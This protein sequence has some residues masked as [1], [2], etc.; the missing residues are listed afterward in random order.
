MLKDFGR[1]RTHIVT[2]RNTQWRSIAANQSFL[3]PITIVLIGLVLLPLAQTFYY[4]LTN[5]NGYS[6]EM[7]F[8]GFRNY[9]RLFS[10]P[11][12][13]SSLWF[14]ALYTIGCVVIVTALAVPTAVILNNNFVGRNFVRSVFFFPSILSIAILGLVWGFLLSPLAS[15]LINNILGTILDITPIPWLSETALAQASVIFVGVWV[16]TGWHAILYLA[17]LQSIPTDYYEAATLDGATPIQQF[18]SIT[19]PLLVPAISISSL[20]LVT[21]GLKVYDL[22]YTLTNGGPGYSTFTVT[23]AIIQNGISQGKVGQ[24]SALSIV[25]MLAVVLVVA[26][27]LFFSR[28][29]EGRLK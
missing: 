3:I 10:D 14:T 12:M 1:T 9:L 26:G 15:G 13:T 25:F 20:L 7:D 18:F 5:F 19:V 28:R 21:A 6:T 4:S 11:A 27:Q 22:P 2:P 8:V 16:Q 23:Q 29:L 24:A 17:Y